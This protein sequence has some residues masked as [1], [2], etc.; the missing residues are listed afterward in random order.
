MSKGMSIDGG[1][2]GFANCMTDGA[3]CK[4]FHHNTE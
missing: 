3:W 2:V 4:E 1:I